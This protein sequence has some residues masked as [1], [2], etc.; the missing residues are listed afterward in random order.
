MF[1]LIAAN[2]DNSDLQAG[3]PSGLVFPRLTQLL[4]YRTDILLYYNISSPPDTWDQLISLAKA[5]HGRDFDGDGVGD[6]ALCLDLQPL[7]SKANYL[8]SAI[9]A[10][11]IQTEAG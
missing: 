10:S 4:F 1:G 9:A 8:L 11:L 3:H 6:F 7:C 2:P 5:L